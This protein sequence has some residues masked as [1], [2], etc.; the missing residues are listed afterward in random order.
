MGQILRID[1]WV[2]MDMVVM[3]VDLQE[4]TVGQPITVKELVELKVLEV[5]VMRTGMQ[6]TV[7]VSLDTEVVM[8]QP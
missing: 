1:R 4:V 2:E 5:F 3:V 6:I 7:R 8:F